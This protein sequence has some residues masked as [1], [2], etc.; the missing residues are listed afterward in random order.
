M[1]TPAP[2]TEDDL[3]IDLEVED[4]PDDKKPEPIM[5][6]IAGK[7]YKFSWS[8]DHFWMQFYSELNSG[9]RL[10]HAAMELIEAS[11]DPM[12]QMDIER[13]LH[14]DP[15]LDTDDLISALLELSARWSKYA[16]RRFEKIGVRIPE[17]VLSRLKK[18]GKAG[19]RKAVIPK[20]KK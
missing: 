15:N 7:E 8:K 19:P 11:I 12:D 4:I 1:T 17:K 10:F 13:R 5:L 2:L 3:D 6:D 20:R 14:T 16:V 18:A 9:K